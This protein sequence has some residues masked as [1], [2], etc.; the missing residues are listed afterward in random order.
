[1]NDSQIIDLYWDRDE[2]AIGETDKKYGPY[3]FSVA[4]RILTSQEDAEECVSDTWFR[5][6]HSMPP[7]R[8]SRLRVFLG[9]ITRNLSFDRYRADT[10]DKRGGG[11]LPLALSELEPCVAGTVSVESHLE[12][13]ELE[14][15]IGRF[16]R[17]LPDRERNVF[18]RRY[19]YVE[20]TKDIAR[21]YGLKEGNVLVILS[22]ARTKLRKHLEQEG[23]MI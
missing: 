13:Q 9:K 11:E 3:C 2:S 14:A 10:A 23:Y 7:Q 1:M 8:P 17:S 20:S 4:R 22:R 21:Q 16:L 5:A 19:F 6:W 18:F 15:S 12:Q